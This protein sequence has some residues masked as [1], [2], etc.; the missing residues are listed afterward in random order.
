MFLSLILVIVLKE[1]AA[2][3]TVMCIVT[4]FSTAVEVLVVWIAILVSDFRM[5]FAA[6]ICEGNKKKQINIG[7]QTIGLPNLI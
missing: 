6:G 5:D 7:C 1:P 4:L 3:I 2:T